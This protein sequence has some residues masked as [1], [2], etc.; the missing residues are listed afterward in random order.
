MG[1]S[2]SLSD[3]VSFAGRLSD[4]E[5]AAESDGPNDVIILKKYGKGLTLLTVAVGAR[6]SAFMRDIAAQT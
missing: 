5:Y 1:I 2:S 3:R 4:E 6:I